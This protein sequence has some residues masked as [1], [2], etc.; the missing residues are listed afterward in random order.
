MGLFQKKKQQPVLKA[1]CDGIVKDITEASDEVFSQKMMGDGILLEPQDGMVYAPCDASVMMCF[2][3]KHAIGLQLDNGIELLLHFGV[4]TV[5]LNGEGFD[6]KVT[7]GDKIACGDLLW[8]ADLAFIK[9]HAVSDELLIIMTANP[10]QCGYEKHL[11]EKKRN[12]NVLE[13]F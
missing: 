4:D 7:A 6:L 11:G 3:T 5:N 10:N 13:F 12:E 2:P 9:E 8:K 1:L